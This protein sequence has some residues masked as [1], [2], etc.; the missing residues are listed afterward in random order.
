MPTCQAVGRMLTLILQKLPL[1]LLQT[2][3]N[4]RG[5]ALFWSE[6]ISIFLDA[7]AQYLDAH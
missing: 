1:P 2:S 3:K 7:S 4:G 5:Q 6:I